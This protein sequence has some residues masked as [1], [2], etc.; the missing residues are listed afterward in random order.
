MAAELP[1]PGVE[2]IQKFRTVTPTVITPTLVPAVVG[3][4]KQIVEL[5]NTSSTGANVLNGDALITLPGLFLA[6]AATGSPAVYTGLD[7]LSLV[8]SVDNAPNV[9]I[10]FKDP[11]ATGLTP[12][13]VV[14]QILAAFADA[15]VTN[16]TAE[17][18][19][20]TQFRVRTLGVGD[21]EQLYVDPTTSGSVLTTFGVGAG[22]TYIGVSTYHQREVLIATS[23]FPDPRHNLD[24]LAIEPETI[25]AFLAMG[26]GT[27]VREASRTTAFLRNGSVNDACVI[28]GLVNM[29]GLTL[30][31]DLTAKTL[32]V[33]VN[34]GAPQTVTFTTSETTVALVVAKITSTLTGVVASGTTF[35]TLTSATVGYAATIELVSGAALV[36]LGLTAGVYH[37]SNIAVVD[38]G[39][40]DVLSPLLEF[41]LENFTSTGTAAVRAG[42]VALSGLSYPGD[43]SNKT[44][45]LSDGKDSQT[46]TFV[47]P[48]NSAAVLTQ[49]NAVM[50]TAAG[51]RLTATL[52]GSNHLVLTNSLTG[53][54]SM[55]EV[56]S[57]TAMTTLGLT[58]AITY[59]GP[60]KVVAGD[61]VWIDGAKVG[62]VRA[63]APGGNTARLKLDRQLTISGNLGTYFY[64]VATGLSSS[65]AADRPLPELI[66]APDGTVTV[67][68]ELSRDT[69]GVALSSQ[70]GRSTVYLS[71]QAVR[72]D[73]TAL[74][75]SP[76]LLKLDSTT[77]LDDQLS[78]VST[79]N[80]LALGLFFALVN[81][82]GVQ[83]T[84][85]GVDAVS[86][87]SPYG[88]VEAFTR[89]AE[90]LEGYEVYAI[91]P[92]THDQTVGQVFST[93]ASF[94][95]EPEQKGERVALFCSAEPANK[96]DILVASGATGNS[97]GSGGTQFDTGVA[98]LS[99]LLLNQ[100]VSPVGTIATA[101]G[102]FLDLELD[103][104][105]YSVSAINGSVV[106]IRT[107]FSAG[108][109]DDGFYATTDLND[110]PLPTTLVNAVFAV[111][112]RGAVLVNTDGTP[113]KQ[114]IAETYQALSQSFGNRR[115][116][117]VMPDTCAATISGIEQ[118]IPGFYMTAA[119]AGMIGQNPPQQSFTNFPMTGLRACSGRTTAS[120]SGS[121]TSWRRAALT[122]WSRTHPVPP[123]CPV[124]RSRPI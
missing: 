83:V 38:D 80:P 102:V 69:T 3:V 28:T 54:E 74:A 67:K 101:S 37:G 55:I 9:T 124:W 75:K 43:L 97:S 39:N 14:A 109:N 98:N 49:I 24:E 78:P 32:V 71:Y 60:A 86:A 123:W 26:G 95:S 100:G 65:P 113:D 103:D 45:E 53:Q 20:T 48:A 34:G 29:T 4:A 122:S 108:T 107:T 77:T 31:G 6:K 42:T 2:I 90:F 91:A 64:I 105:H 22:R 116:W 11:T 51:G 70:N 82:P 27:N 10:T 72:E 104:K 121:S 46:I 68:H 106:T 21:L 50:G 63:V 25:R 73:V 84:G 8:L 118:K 19:G 35:L 57:G 62:V 66:V 120:A 56:V 61:E 79:L 47:T 76:G 59:G 5:F 44:L 13:T 85:L 30:P 12:A 16:A 94:M 117:H 33:K 110:P 17:T 1:R 36:T 89:A 114:S 23:N 88:T 111:R 41:A 81:A 15:G 40:G 119:I 96:L 58:A 87:D 115:F 18:V 92:L 99:A 7:G 52:D 93:H 112:V